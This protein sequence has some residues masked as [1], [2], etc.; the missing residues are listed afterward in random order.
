[1]MLRL[2]QACVHSELC[3]DYESQLENIGESDQALDAK[4]AN[5][6]YALIKDSGNDNCCVCGVSGTILGDL[7]ENME[8]PYVSKCGHLFCAGCAKNGMPE[9]PSCQTVLGKSDV[10]QVDLEGVEADEVSPELYKHDAGASTKIKAL[11]RDLVYLKKDC[12]V[13]KLQ[14]IKCIVFSQ[15]TRFLDMIEVYLKLMIYF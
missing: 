4:R 2:R 14:P 11:V 6:L 10:F 9:C 3:K 5:H 1:M 13:R 12:E 7:D 8:S 15:W